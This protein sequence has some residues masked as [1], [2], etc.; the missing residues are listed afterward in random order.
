MLGLAAI[1]GTMF[2]TS[3]L[4]FMYADALGVEP[5][6][7]PLLLLISIAV[8]MLNPSNTFH[9]G[10]RAL[11]LRT[12]G[13]IVLSPFFKVEFADFWMADQ[14]MSMVQMLL[15]LKYCF[16]FYLTR[17]V[18]GE[19]P[20]LVGEGCLD[21]GWWAYGV[22]AALPAYFRIQQCI[23]KSIDTGD[24]FPH[25]ANTGKYLTSLS[26][27]VLTTI[28]TNSGADSPTITVWVALIVASSL[29]G[30]VWD[31]KMDWRLMQENAGHNK[32]LRHT[33]LY[34]KR[35][36]YY[37]A[38]LVDLVLRFSW[39]ISLGLHQVLNSEYTPEMCITIF[40]ALEIFRRFVWNFFRLENEQL[41]NFKKLNTDLLAV[42]IDNNE[43]TDDSD[44]EDS[45]DSELQRHSDLLQRH[46]LLLKEQ[47]KRAME[48]QRRVGFPKVAGFGK[49]WQLSSSYDEIS[50]SSPLLQERPCILGSSYG[51]C[52]S[53]L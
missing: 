51:A 1:F 21:H 16:L 24:W 38:V 33:L 42:D 40:S 41:E 2:A 26:V 53:G 32:F 27:V 19:W 10:A 49:P 47:R 44:Q 3:V 9:R 39:L 15:D 31:I 45:C 23:R 13:R 14:L 35:V 30:F 50:Q 48:K 4:G 5:N 28:K 17:A 12:M 11:V 29:Y 52:G 7:M 36:V 34:E 43:Q 37:L 18:D 20:G 22:V 6:L 8:F 46:E 25:L